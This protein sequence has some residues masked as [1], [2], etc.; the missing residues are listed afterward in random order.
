MYCEL[1]I[2]D[3]SFALLKGIGDFF[4]PQFYN[5]ANMRKSQF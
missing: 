5:W 4:N 2:Y 1:G 3:G